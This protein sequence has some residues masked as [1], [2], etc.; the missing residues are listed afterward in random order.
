MF[1]ALVSV[2][3][4]HSMQVALTLTPKNRVGSYIARG[5]NSDVVATRCR[6][7]SQPG[8]AQLEAPYLNHRLCGFMTGLRSR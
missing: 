7:L 2:S 1:R 4:E 8:T 3:K 6:K 5:R